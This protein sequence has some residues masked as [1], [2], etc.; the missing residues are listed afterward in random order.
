[1]A[2][3]WILNMAV[4]RWGLNKK[5][6]VGPVS[7]WIREV[8][9]E[10]LEEWEKAYL[11]RLEAFLHKKKIPLTPR[12]YLRHLGTTLYVKVTEVLRREL[13]EV[14]EEDCIQYLRNLVIQ[15][16]FEGYQ[17]ERGVVYGILQE[18][19]R[20][21]GVDIQAAPDEIDRRYHVDFWIP[22][23]GKYVG[24]QIKPVTYEQMQ[25][26]HRWEQWMKA[27]HQR[28][29]KRY[30]GRVFVVYSHKEGRR[31]VMVNPEVLQQIREEIQRLRR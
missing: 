24:I 8:D 14:T 27:A 7:Q 4:N 2:K 26:L 22:V 1:V 28:F 15:R 9:P 11:Q 13:E 10:S 6:R 18:A 31:P 21:L 12:E 23:R 25:D 20:D 29:Q 16:T 30:G 19:L 5:S 3:E 17:R